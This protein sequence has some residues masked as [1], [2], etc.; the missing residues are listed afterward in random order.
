MLDAFTWYKQSAYKWQGDGLTV[1]IDPWDVPDGEPAGDLVLITHAHADHFSR[2][3][4]DSVSGDGTVLVAPHDIAEQLSGDVR[5]VR[6]GET[7][8]AVGLQI[9]TFPAYNIAPDRQ[10]KHPRA[11][12]WVGYIVPLGGQRCCFTGDTD[13]T[14]ELTAVKAEV[15]FVCIGGTFTMDVDEATGAI[16]TMAPGLAVPNHYGFVVGSK[17]DGP[18]FVDAIKPTKGYVMEPVHPFAQ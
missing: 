13:N 14:P 16:K 15:V 18:R 2:D 6:P 7:I 8:E 10:D 9:E 5:A 1:Y 11:N 12:G 3:D 4:I 17:D